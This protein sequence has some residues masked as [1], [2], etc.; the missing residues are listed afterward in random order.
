MDVVLSILLG[1]LGFVVAF[2]LFR[3]IT[4]PLLK[5]FGFYEYYSPMMFTVPFGPRQLELH[6]GTTWDFFRQSNL[7]QQQIILHLA[8]GCLGLIEAAENGLIP[9]STRLRG[10]V[11]Y[12]RTTTLRRF[13]FTERPMNL[14]ETFVFLLNYLELSLLQSIMKKRVALVNLTDV[15]IVNA[16]IKDLVEHRQEVE[17]LVRTLE[18]KLGQKSPFLSVT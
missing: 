11:Y 5:K 9:S 17:K 16:T 6:V 7:T 14:L 15:R 8:K 2:R 10:T 3:W 18:S 13:G 4:T 1:T 12:F